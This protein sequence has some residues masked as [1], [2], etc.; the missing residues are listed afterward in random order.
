MSYDRQ[1]AGPGG[2]VDIARAV[3]TLPMRAG[4]VYTMRWADGC[5]F[6]SRRGDAQR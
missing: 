2:D 6:G 1:I 5:R 3:S 4:E